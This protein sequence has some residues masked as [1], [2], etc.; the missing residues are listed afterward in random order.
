[1]PVVA[2][3]PAGTALEDVRG[4]ALLGDDPGPV[5]GP[6][7]P[8]TGVELVAAAVTLAAVV[9]ALA[10]LQ[11]AGDG[12]VADPGRG[13]GGAGLD[14]SSVDVGS[15]LKLAEFFGCAGEA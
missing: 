10:L 11:N 6:D 4:H 14:D 12:V 3:V 2:A 7:A 13:L 9:G 15:Q 5:V 1:M 8:T